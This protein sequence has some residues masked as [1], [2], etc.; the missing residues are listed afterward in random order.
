MSQPMLSLGGFN[1][2]VSTATYQQLVRSHEWRWQAQPRVGKRDILQYTGKAAPTRSL[3]GQIATMF[4][5]TGTGQIQKLIDLA[6]KGQPLLMMS[7][8]GDKL[9]YWC[10]K[11]VTETNTGFMSGGTPRFQTFQLDLIFYGDDLQNP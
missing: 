4:Q 11:S 6:N 3:N 8:D 9:G 2:A 10:I 7:G 5:N 1:F